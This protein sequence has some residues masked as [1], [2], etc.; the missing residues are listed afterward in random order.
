MAGATNPPDIQ[1]KTATFVTVAC[2]TTPTALLVPC[3]SR[4]VSTEVDPGD[5]EELDPWWHAYTETRSIAR[6]PASERTLDKAGFADWWNEL[7]PWWSIYTEIGHE[8]AIDIADLLEQFNEAWRQSAAHFDTDPMSSALTPNSGPLFPSKEEDWSR[9]LANLLRH[10]P[11]L[12]TDLFDISIDEPPEQV[13][14]ETRLSKDEGGFRRPDILVLYPERGISIEVKI[15]DTNYGKTEETARLTERKYPQQAWTHALLLPE[16]YTGRLRANLEPSV[17]E[18]PEDGLQVEWDDP[19][20]VSVVFWSDVAAAIRNL[21]RRGDTVDDHWA[22]NAYLFC[23][24]VEQR[25]MNFAPEPMIERMADPVG[26]VDETQALMLAGELEEQ[27][28]YLRARA[29][30]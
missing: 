22:A 3:T 5:W 2:R 4:D 26:V 1:H 21:L 20:P 10:A 9:W 23:A 29:N 7:D 11:A 28:T 14:R 6:S 12:V 24:A 13:I 27:L 16:R 19:G 18:H 15:G 8:T 30:A 17:S 25:I